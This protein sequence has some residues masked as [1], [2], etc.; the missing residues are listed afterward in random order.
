MVLESISP[1][2]GSLTGG[3]GVTIKGNGFGNSIK[4]CSVLLGN[5][6]CDVKSINMSTIVCVTTTHVASNVTVNVS[7]TLLYCTLF[8]SF[9]SLLCLIKFALLC[10]PLCLTLLDLTIFIL[11]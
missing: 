10:L 2:K 11:F 4:D 9:I 7:F 1:N 5:A 6:T 8:R 3:T